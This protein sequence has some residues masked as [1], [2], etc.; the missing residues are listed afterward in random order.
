MC[1]QADIGDGWSIAAAEAPGARITRQHVLD[2]AAARIEPVPEP[3]HSGQ[4]IEMKLLFEIFSHARDDKGMRVHSHHLSKPSYIAATDICALCSS[5]VPDPS[6][7][8]QRLC[9]ST[10]S[11]AACRR[12]PPRPLAPCFH[13]PRPHS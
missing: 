10:N 2:R 4:L 5:K 11:V 13:P 12:Q 6:C 3:L 1:D 9:R 7:S 8:R